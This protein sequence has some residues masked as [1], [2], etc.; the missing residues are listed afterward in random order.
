M[1]EKPIDRLAEEAY[2]FMSAKWYSDRVP[3]LEELKLTAEAKL[4]DIS[5]R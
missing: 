5:I 3:G 2:D 1:E 4:L